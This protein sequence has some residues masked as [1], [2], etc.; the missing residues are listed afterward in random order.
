MRVVF[1]C[2]ASNRIG[3]G[4][5]VRCATL[6]HAL[7]AAG[8]QTKFLCAELP[9][10][11]NHWLQAQGL[12]VQGLAANRDET[13]D[14]KASCAYLDIADW[15][16][17]DHYALGATW[18][19]SLLPHCR[20][21]MAIDDIDRPH[22]AHLVL[23]QNRLDSPIAP[24]SNALFGPRYAL[25]RPEF[26]AQRPAALARRNG[27]FERLLVTFGGADEANE[28]AKVLSILPDLPDLAVDVVIGQ[29]HAHQATIRQTCHNLGARCRLHIQTKDMAG[30]MARADCAI[31][32][33][34]STTW[35]RCVM[36]LPGLVSIAADNQA[37]IAANVAR[38][39]AQQVLG[40]QSA[41]YAKDY[42]AA[43]RNLNQD[44]L[45]S[46]TRHAAALCDGKGPGRVVDALVSGLKSAT[47]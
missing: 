28:T 46:Q 39:G 11:L 24:E 35:E 17:V 4:H 25:I 14:A 32:A 21:L 2:D 29:S 38:A 18:E 3:S 27:Q 41:L 15:L 6:A 8:H 10:H 31:T 7:I 12:S 22:L 30:L 26:A 20:R 43:I 33:G 42:L 1:R 5:V 44:S 47:P 19:A 34:G 45:L 40:W 36:G 16:I 9:G 13:N 23:D 37:D